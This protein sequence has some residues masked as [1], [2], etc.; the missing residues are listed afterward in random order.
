MIKTYTLKGYDQD[1][2]LTTLKYSVL[3]MARNEGLKMLRRSHFISLKNSN[4]IKLT[5]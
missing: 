3:K 2:K 5:L 4:G 1:N